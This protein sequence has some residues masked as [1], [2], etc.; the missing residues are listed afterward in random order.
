MVQV[1]HSAICTTDVEQSLRFWRDGLGFAVLFE[2]S[3]TGDWPTLFGAPSENLR[4][5][6]LGDPDH[7]EGGMLELVD[8][9]DVAAS[10]PPRDTTA[11]FL[12][13]SVFTDIDEALAR[14]ADLALDRD[15]REI[16]VDGGIRMAVVSDPNGVL[17]E[18]V[19][20][21][22]SENIDHLRQTASADRAQA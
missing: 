18:L 21:R 2:H 6:F 5:I 19:S 14:L 16:T 17:V 13:L 10:P 15:V 12:L 4:A 1:H 7:L 11:G 20:P 22:A 8:L 9:G 3:F